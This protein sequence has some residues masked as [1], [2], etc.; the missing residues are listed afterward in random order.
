MSA[1]DTLIKT[2]LTCIV[3]PMGCHLNVE[4]SEEGFKV[5]GNTCK[6]GEKYAVQELTNPTRVITTTVKLENSYLQLL[7]VKTEDPIPKGMIFDIMEALDK[8]RV[9]APVKV[10][11]VIVENILDTVV[12]VISAKTMD[13]M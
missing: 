6:R 3:C 4:Q 9:N 1:V 7:P 5:E 2:E 12:D 13:V 8:V 11:D 10:G